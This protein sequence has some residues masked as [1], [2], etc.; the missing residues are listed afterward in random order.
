MWSKEAKAKMVEWDYKFKEGVDRIPWG[1]Y[2]LSL[3]SVVAKRSCD[4]QT[5]HGAVIVGLNK[6]ILSTGYNGFVRGINDEVLPNL[7]PE[8]YTW[9]IHAEH[10]AIL[11]CAR[12]GIKLQ[13]STIYVT[14]PPCIYCLQYIYQVGITHIIHYDVPHKE[15]SVYNKQTVEEE[16]F[17]ELTKDKLHITMIKQTQ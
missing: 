13:N 7:R 9:M 2:F 16:I 12:N 3:A 4:P 14:G 6:E 5:Q 8:K 10:N 1:D 11:N 17:K 15:H